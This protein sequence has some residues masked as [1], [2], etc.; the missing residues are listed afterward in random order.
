MKQL[1]Y[2]ILSR[3]IVTRVYRYRNLSAGWSHRE[4][5]KVIRSVFFVLVLINLLGSAPSHYY[6]VVFFIK[7]SSIT[8]LGT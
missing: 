3:H 8:G 1:R 7:T 4:K 2:L 6:V 5:V